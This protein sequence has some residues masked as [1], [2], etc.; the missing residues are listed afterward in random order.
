MFTP[1]YKSKNVYYV[2]N[3]AQMHNVFT[4]PKILSNS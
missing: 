4:F 1:R 3:I 2:P